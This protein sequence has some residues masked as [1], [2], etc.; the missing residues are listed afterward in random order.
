MDQLE[1]DKCVA[2]FRF[3]KD[4]IYDLPGVLQIP[5]EIV[6]Y[7]GTKASDIEALCIFLKRNAYPCIYLDLIQRFARPVTELCIINNIVL[8]FLYERWGHLFTTVN[9]QTISKTI[10]TISKY[11]LTLLITKVPL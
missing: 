2:E 5:D 7:N 8:K 4:D 9:Q 1:N 10:Q 11:L 6:R 3:Q